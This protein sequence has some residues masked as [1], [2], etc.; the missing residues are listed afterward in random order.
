M[1][2]QFDVN[3]FGTVAIIK[4]V[5]P[6]MRQRRAE[7]IITITSVG[8]LIPSTTLGIYNGSK[9][10]LEGITRSLAAEVSR[11]GIHVT[12]VEPG[13]F[14]TDWSGRSLHHA[15]RSIPDYD[16]L[17]DPISNTPAGFNG[18]QPAIPTKPATRYCS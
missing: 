15:A 12:A 2:R 17:I 18:R 9:F 11:F 7:H 14:R 13:A 16:E 1:R 4:A 10:A 3:V 5:V 6:G 8:G